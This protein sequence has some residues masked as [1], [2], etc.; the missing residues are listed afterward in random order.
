MNQIS[1]KVSAAPDIVKEYFSNPFLKKKI[2]VNL[3]RARN[4]EVKNP[5]DGK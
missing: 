3:E 5:V 2:L 1:V 4:T